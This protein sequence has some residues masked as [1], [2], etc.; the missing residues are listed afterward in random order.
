MV[1]FKAII[2]N[3][4][5]DKVWEKLITEPVFFSGFEWYI[6][7]VHIGLCDVPDTIALLV[8]KT[9]ES[10]EEKGVIPKLNERAAFPWPDSP[11]LL[12]S[13]EVGITSCC[14]LGWGRPRHHSL[15]REG[16]LGEET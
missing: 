12:T 9:P 1:N 7:C 3:S 2:Y 11:G 13:M 16:S 15:K 4:W 10:H 6:E 8:P 14:K 5:Q